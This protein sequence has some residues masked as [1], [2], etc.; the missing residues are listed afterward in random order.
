[1]PTVIGKSL[2]QKRSLFAEFS[3]PLSS[4][5]PSGETV[6]LRA[7]LSR[8]VRAQVQEFQNRQSERQF[9]RVLTQRQIDLGAEQGKINPA[10]AEVSPQH[11][12]P[13]TAVETALL[14]YLDGLYLVVI[15][16]R[17]IE[18]LDEEIDLTPD[19]RITFIRLTLLAGG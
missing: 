4:D 3:I 9:I 8:I 19:S 14:A 6:V 13:D 18:N 7:L 17:Q 15:D 10:A 16:D 12:D 1:M 5:T 2:G 11:V